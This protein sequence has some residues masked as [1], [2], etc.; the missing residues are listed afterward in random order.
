MALGN[1]N[2]NADGSGAAEVNRISGFSIRDA[3]EA[4]WRAL[5]GT[6]GQ[7]VNVAPDR[8]TRDAYWATTFRSLGNT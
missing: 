8:E 2:A 6:N 5:T 4:M 1:S 3:R 7:G